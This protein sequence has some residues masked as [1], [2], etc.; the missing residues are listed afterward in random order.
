MKSH[1]PIRKGKK[2]T[3]RTTFGATYAP[4]TLFPP[5]SVSY[6]ALVGVMA[7]AS[8]QVPCL[9]RPDLSDDDGTARAACADY[10][11]VIECAA[12]TRA[13][14]QDARV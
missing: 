4:A 2:L 6:T 5:R 14:R 13:H 1:N 7:S 8:E 11:T 3:T 9:S 10:P 12:Y